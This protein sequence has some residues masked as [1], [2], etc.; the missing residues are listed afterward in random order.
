MASTRR[1]F[2]KKGTLAVTL[3][4]AAGPVLSFLPED[5]HLHAAGLPKKRAF[6][7]SAKPRKV[8]EMVSGLLWWDAAD[9]EEYG[10]WAL[11]TQFVAFMGS[12]YLIA[13]G[14]SEPV[15]DAVTSVQIN[16]PGRYRLWVRSRNWVP[17]HSPGQFKASVGGTDSNE[18]FGAQSKSGWSWQDG[19][20]VE[21]PTG[22][23][24]L[25][26]KDQTGFFSRCSSLILSRDLDYRP[27]AELD[28][29]KAERARL[30]GIPAQA[31]NFGGYDVVVVG[32][33]PAGTCAAIAAAREGARTLLISDRPVLG[34]NA[35]EEIQ[36]PVNGAADHL[37]KEGCTARE[38]GLIEE[39]VR[40]CHA[41]GWWHNMTRAFKV[42]VDAEPNLQL[43]KNSRVT[44]VQMNG[45]SIRSVEW[46][47]TLDGLRGTASAPVYIDATGDGWIGYF[48]G[49]ARRIGNEARSEFNESLAP[50]KAND[51]SMSGCLRAPHEGYSRGMFYRSIERRKPVPFKRPGWVYTFDD[52]WRRTR[53]NWGQ[54]SNALQNGTWWMEH[55]NTIDDFNY[56]EEAR[57]ELI[58]IY[59]SIW[60]YLKND[61]HNKHLAADF[62]LDYVPFANGRRESYRLEGDHIMTQNDLQKPEAFPDAIG[63]C[64]WPM[65]IHAPGGVFDTQGT[66][67][68]GLGNNNPGSHV[69]FGSQIP[70]RSLYSRNIDNLL[71][72]GR[73]ISVSRLALGSVRIEGTCAVT[74]QA[75]GTGAALCAKYELTPRE[76]YRTRMNELQ[77][78]LLKN[79]QFIPDVKN[80]D[81]EDLARRATV[82]ASSV[83]P[84]G[85]D[86]EN[87]LNGWTRQLGVNQNIWW[88]SSQQNVP[89]WIRLDFPQAVF[90]RTVQC[91]FD[92]NLRPNAWHSGQNPST[93]VREY[94][95]EC[96]VDGEWIPVV[97]EKDNFLRLRRHSFSPVTADAVRLTVLR[98][99]G[100]RCARVFEMRVYGGGIPA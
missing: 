27:P 83:E 32:A 57:D 15:E 91:T 49:A 50:E 48:A 89:Q 23:C 84:G 100:I 21:L 51:L 92:T 31:K 12:S 35:S 86:P 37:S 45:S 87:I 13:H 17:E 61:W 80:L 64:G 6:R 54:F 75:A 98:T 88:S 16:T 52:E 63:H 68:P 90:I 29:F 62:E 59:F 56:P 95:I 19:G 4:G 11:D 85:Y 38:S 25:R 99:N 9:F 8:T 93:C 81:P 46:E 7:K 26:L 73:N 14:T 20:V 77:Q 34:G 42:L 97:F 18:S 94:R 1:D 41:N 69:P 22:R 96:R 33:G 76:L 55:C 24:E 60:N 74:G 53:G 70:F 43:V 47:N 10:G 67:F 79:D 58:R 39:A 72:A 78:T 40:I 36:V 2:I 30:I 44:G 65:D 3:A 71:M 28:A 82:S 5:R 66:F